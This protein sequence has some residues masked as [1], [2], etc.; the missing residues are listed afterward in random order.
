MTS[1]PHQAHFASRDW[2]LYPGGGLFWPDHAAL[3]VADLHLGKDATFRAASVGVPVGS[4]PATLDAVS[5]MLDHSGSTELFVLGDLFHSRSSLSRET[6]AAF[7]QFL[8]QHRDID[9]TLIRGNHDRHVGRLPDRWNL[10]IVEDSLHLDGVLLTHFP[11]SCPDHADLLIAGHLHPADVIS[12]R[13]ESTGKLP[14]FWLHQRCLTLPA[15]G[16]FTG[17]AKVDRR[18]GDRVWLIA[19]HTVI[20]RSPAAAR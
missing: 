19:D 4:T 5:Q 1:T 8:T 18:S 2:Q 10:N 17:T 6:V 13:G 12:V 3:M 14:C 15:C 9:V 11:G 20:E 7:E 16:H